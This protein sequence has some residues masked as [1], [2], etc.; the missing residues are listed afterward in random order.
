MSEQ[1]R[2]AICQRCKIGF[3]VTPYYREHL[4][5]WGARVTVPQLCARCFHKT[6]PFPKQRGTIKWFDP[7]K[8]YGFIVDEQGEQIFVHQSALY[9]ANGS[10]PREGQP[11][12]YHVHYALKGPKAL[13]VEL[14]ETAHAS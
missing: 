11:A 7:H 14:L 3:L 9:Q 5:L 6:G 8:H 12:L 1:S 13:N 2:I 10:R 4:L